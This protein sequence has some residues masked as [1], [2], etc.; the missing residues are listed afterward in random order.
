MAIY[1][2]YPGIKGNASEHAHKDWIECE[3]ISLG[4]GRWA[5]DEVG[6]G[7]QTQGTHVEVGDVTL[8]KPM[9]MASPHLFLASVVGWS[10]KEVKIH[11]TRTGKSD[12]S[13]Y[14]EM[15]LHNCCVTG[16]STTSDKDLHTETLTL[17]FTKIEMKYHPVKP[18]LETA[19][20]IP[21]SFDI[22][23]DTVA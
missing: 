2:E 8:T 14:L 4:A 1:L 18:T 7:S 9:C 23:T 20:G 10:V 5:N 11:I 17:N 22:P 6:Q 21:V 13:N 3:S 12:Q 15:T 16:H 19:G